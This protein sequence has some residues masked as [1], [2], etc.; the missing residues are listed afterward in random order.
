MRRFTLASTFAALAGC[1]TVTTTVV[2][3]GPPVPYAPKA[4]VEVLLEAPRRTH[5]RIAMLEGRGHPGVSELDVLE[6]LR[7]RAKALGA[8]AI[9]RDETVTT[10]QPPTEVFEPFYDPFFPSRRLF[11]YRYHPFGPPYGTYRLVGGGYLY[12]VKATALKYDALAP[13]T[14]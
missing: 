1:A 4:E 7:E 5:R 2:P 14:R 11:P 6:T 9:V 13:D 8:D 12:T 3:L 10:Y